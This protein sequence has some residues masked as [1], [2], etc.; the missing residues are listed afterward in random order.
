MLTTYP[1]ANYSKRSQLEIRD[2]IV[3]DNSEIQM[4]TMFLRKAEKEI[5]EY[6][7]ISMVVPGIIII[8][9]DSI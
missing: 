6:K 3:Q 5:M 8:R 4:M 7:T 9:K 1:V 2:N